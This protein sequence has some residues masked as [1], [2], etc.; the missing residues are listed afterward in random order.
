[1]CILRITR[2][3]ISTGLG[4]ILQAIILNLHMHESV[5]VAQ[6]LSASVTPLSRR[7]HL[8]GHLIILPQRF[9]HKHY[10]L[11]SLFR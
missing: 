10:I 1:M 9:I 6:G 5:Q 3:A 11:E 4:T 2:R 8:L 7:L